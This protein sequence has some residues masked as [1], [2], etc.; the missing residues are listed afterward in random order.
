[1]LIESTC[2]S[3]EVMFSF[4]P[5]PRNDSD[6]VSVK[7]DG[8]TT[9]TSVTSVVNYRGMLFWKL[10][11]AQNFMFEINRPSES[12]VSKNSLL[13]R[14]VPEKPSSDIPEPTP[15]TTAMGLYAPLGDTCDASDDDDNGDINA[16]DELAR[17]LNLI[18]LRKYAEGIIK[19]GKYHS[20]VY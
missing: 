6:F 8:Q 2:N 7:S 1:M 15:N 19:K 12:I 13:V 20:N 14:C 5:I 4:G 18:K 17:A 9:F 3:G 11:A 16:L 10:G